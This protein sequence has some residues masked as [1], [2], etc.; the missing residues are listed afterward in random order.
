MHGQVFTSPFIV[1]LPYSAGTEGLPN[2][3]IRKQRIGA[4]AAGEAEVGPYFGG[5]VRCGG[6][7]SVPGLVDRTLAGGGW[8]WDVRIDDETLFVSLSSMILYV[9]GFTSEKV[10]FFGGGAFVESGGLWGD[11]DGDRIA[12]GTGP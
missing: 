2:E 8:K 1:R 11:T 7:L 4:L 12:G 9:A 5:R 6:G 10:G 3:R